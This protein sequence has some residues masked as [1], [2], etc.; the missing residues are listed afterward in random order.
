[1]PPAEWAPALIATLLPE[2][3]DPKL[4]DELAR[5]LGDLHPSATRTSLQA[6]AEADLRDTLPEVNVPTLLL[7]GERDVR[8]TRAVWEPIHADIAHSKLVVIPGAGHMIDMQAPDRCNT[9]IRS[10]LRET[11]S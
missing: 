2:G 4:A 7:Y 6:F 11:E 3:S 1:M 10:F 8:T 9:E 5:M